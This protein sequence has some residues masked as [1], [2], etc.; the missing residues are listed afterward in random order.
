MNDE[1]RFL[2]FLGGAKIEVGVNAEVHQSKFPEGRTDYTMFYGSGD[3][4]VEFTFDKEGNL[5][6]YVIGGGD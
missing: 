4:F 1:D 5:M 3:H 6:E 2:A